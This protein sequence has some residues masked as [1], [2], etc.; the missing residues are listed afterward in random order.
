MVEEFVLFHINV[1]KYTFPFKLE[2]N[3][4]GKE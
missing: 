4:P 1:K 2:N 3:L